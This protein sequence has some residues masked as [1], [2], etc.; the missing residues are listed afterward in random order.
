MAKSFTGSRIVLTHIQ[1]KSLKKARKLARHL[2]KIEKNC[3]IQSVTFVLEDSFICC[4]V[5]VDKLNRTPMEMTLRDMI[6]KYRN[7]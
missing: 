2:D 4:D 6:K 5:E 7:A 3:G 1:V